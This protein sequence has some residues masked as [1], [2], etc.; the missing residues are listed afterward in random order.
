MSAALPDC[1]AHVCRG[2][3]QYLATLSQ[4]A[5]SV[6]G[7]M[8]VTVQGEVIDN[9]FGLPSIASHTM[10]RYTT[11][12]LTATLTPPSEPSPE[13]RDIMQ[14]LSEESCDKYRAIVYDDPNFVEYF[15]SATPDYESVP[16][17]ATS[18]Q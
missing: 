17:T 16:S 11:S 10:E 2:G 5:G 14:Q 9:L 1:C 6:Q 4:P 15:R 8:R 12:V 13:F 18:R 3:P 7:W